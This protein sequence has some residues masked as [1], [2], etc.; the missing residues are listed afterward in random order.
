MFREFFPVGLTAFDKLDEAFLWVKPTMSHLRARAEVRELLLAI[1]LPVDPSVAHPDGERADDVDEL[2]G[3]T[4][5]LLPSI[6]S[7]RKRAS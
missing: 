4:P 2:S 7:E 5:L 3:P 1:G 6:D